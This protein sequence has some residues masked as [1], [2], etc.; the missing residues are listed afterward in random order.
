MNRGSQKT[1]DTF[2]ESFESFLI[3]TLTRNITSESEH[4][5]IFNEALLKRDYEVKSYGRLQ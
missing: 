5:A 3:T 2:T 1:G 4:I